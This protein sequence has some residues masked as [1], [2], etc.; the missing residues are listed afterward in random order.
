VEGREGRAVRKG[1]EIKENKPF[2]FGIEWH[3]FLE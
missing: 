2:S 3:R 1:K